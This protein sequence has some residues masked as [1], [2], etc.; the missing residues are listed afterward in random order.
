MTE[1][2]DIEILKGRPPNFDAIQRKLRG[3]WGKTTVFT[4]GH[5]IYVADGKPIPKSIVAHEVI[6]VRQQE[7]MGRDEWWERY[8]ADPA[9]RFSQE[10]EAHRMELSVALTEGGRKHRRMVAALIAKRLSGPLYDNHCTL[11]H[12]KKLLHIGRENQE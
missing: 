4:Y 7:I 9:F 6:H 12:A 2:L 10:L 11:S 3:A 8:L 5:Q 1:Q